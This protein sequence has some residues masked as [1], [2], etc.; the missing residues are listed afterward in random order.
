MEQKNHRPK[1]FTK[2][3]N[4]YRG[5]PYKPK[6]EKHIQITLSISQNLLNEIEQKIIGKTRSEKITK[7]IQRGVTVA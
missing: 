5:R 2:S 3:N 4:P 1:A 6:E 7:C